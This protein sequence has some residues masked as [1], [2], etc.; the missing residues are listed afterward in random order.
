MTGAFTA[1]RARNYPRNGRASVIWMA[2]QIA[3][4]RLGSKIGVCPHFFE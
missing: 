4:G 1:L 3:M 2:F